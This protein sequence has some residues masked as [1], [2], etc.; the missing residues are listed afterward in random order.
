[1]NNPLQGLGDKAKLIQE[2][3]KM[4]KEIQKE[5]VTVN[6]NGVIVIASGDQKIVSII[7]NGQSDER[8]REAINEALKKSQEAAAKK[9]QQMGGMGGLG[10]LLGK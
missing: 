8:I 6:K 4:Q 1:M 7:T 9:I 2:A 3:M 5:Q 10:G